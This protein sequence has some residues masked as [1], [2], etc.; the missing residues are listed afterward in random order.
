M[1]WGGCSSRSQGSSTKYRARGNHSR[2]YLRRN[3]VHGPPAHTVS[4][5]RTRPPRTD[6]QNSKIDL[7]L[8]QPAESDHQFALA[9]STRSSPTTSLPCGTSQSKEPQGMRRRPDSRD[10]VASP[11]A[12]PHK[13]D[14]AERPPAREEVR[15]TRQAEFD[16]FYQAAYPRLFAQLHAILGDCAQA[17]AAAQEAFTRAWRRWSTVR[18]LPDP[19]GWVRR[20]AMH[21]RNPRW[22][23]APA[24]R[25][26]GEPE[27]VTT[28]NHPPNL[29]VFD[30]LS[31]LP[32]VQRRALVLHHMAGLSPEQI[33]DEE[34]TSESTIHARLAH[35]R[36]ALAHRLHG[37]R[38]TGLHGGKDPC[39]AP[40][41]RPAGSDPD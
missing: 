22:Q 32:A 6:A 35:G 27:H 12:R 8:E 14:E 15:A 9:A 2:N 13:T 29:A 34:S 5:I 20:V 28:M 25:S 37:D 4:Q 30:A 17:H 3:H 23:R 7:R 40:P 31:Q 18:A 16:R 38:R 19:T 36:L 10:P 11:L 39:L 41:E 21:V 24:G 26:G 1:S 33:A